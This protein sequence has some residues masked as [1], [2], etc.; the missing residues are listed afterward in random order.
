MKV[1]HIFFQLDGKV[2]PCTCFCLVARLFPFVAVCNPSMSQ[3]CGWAM[4]T[5]ARLLGLLGHPTLAGTRIWLIGFPNSRWLQQIQQISCRIFHSNC[6]FHGF[7]V[8]FFLCFPLFLCHT[9]STAQLPRWM[10]TLRRRPLPERW[11]QMSSSPGSF[12]DVPVGGRTRISGW[13]HGSSWDFMGFNGISWCETAA[14][15]QWG[16]DPIHNY[17]H[18][19]PIS[20]R[21]CQAGFIQLGWFRE[22]LEGTIPILPY[23]ISA[24]ASQVKVMVSWFLWANPLVY[25]GNQQITV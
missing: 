3:G 2:S 15:R 21:K 25:F 18:N 23:Y 22:W 4:N 19:R 5:A 20:I 24:A 12:R 1:T 10:Q 14:K 8:G 11:R 16:D 7:S 17:F 13:L 6:V 9:A